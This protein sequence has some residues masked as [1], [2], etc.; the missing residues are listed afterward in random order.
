MAR[1]TT[2]ICA[3]PPIAPSACAMNGARQDQI[4]SATNRFC[5]VHAIRVRDCGRVAAVEA[6]GKW[7]AFCAFHF[8]MAS[9]LEKN[10]P[11][12]EGG[13]FECFGRGPVLREVECPFRQEECCGSSPSEALSRTH[14]HLPGDGIQMP[15]RVH[16]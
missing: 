13:R 5:C 12:D 6:V 15:L 1:P 7:E 3:G 8:S 14:I 4:P 10:L 16:R 9:V 2:N 11:W